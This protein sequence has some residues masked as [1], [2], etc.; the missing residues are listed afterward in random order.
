MENIEAGFSKENVDDTFKQSFN[1]LKAIYDIAVIF[2]SYD[3]NI[4]ALIRLFHPNGIVFGEVSEQKIK[5]V[6]FK[7]LGIKVDENELIS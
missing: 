6:V 5:K 3:A 7:D 4:Y 2:D 1:A